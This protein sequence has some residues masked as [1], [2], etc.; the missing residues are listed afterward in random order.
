[1]IEKAEENAMLAILLRSGGYVAIIVLGFLL[2]RFGV[3]KEDDFRVISTLVIKVTLPAAVIIN[4]TGKDMD[5]SL[6]SLALLGLVC[7]AFYMAVGYVLHRKGT[8]EE[9]AFALLNYSSYNIGN[10][11]L[12]F[13]QSFLGATGVIVAS[14]FDVGNAMVCLGGSAAVAD[15]VRRGGRLSLGRLVRAMSRAVSFVTCIVM[16]VLTLLHITLPQ[17]ILHCVGIAANANVFL[18]LLMIGVGFRLAGERSQVRYILRFLA[19]RYSVAVVLAVVCWFLLPFDA[20][21]RRTLVVLL[22]APV[23]SANLPFTREMEGDV[24]LASAMSSVSIACSIVIIVA[25]LSFMG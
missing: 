1:M 2:R 19:A 12:P 20:E 21:I 15:V 7:A 3:L 17:P 4:F 22:F 14:L 13:V 18:S 11:T 24:G 10:F 25:L 5:V 9:K 16:T 6:L 8:P 23:A